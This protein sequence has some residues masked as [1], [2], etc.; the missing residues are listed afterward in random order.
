VTYEAFLERVLAALDERLN[1][2]GYAAASLLAP[3]PVPFV[4]APVLAQGGA[5]A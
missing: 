5:D 1:F 3:Q 2:F 4:F